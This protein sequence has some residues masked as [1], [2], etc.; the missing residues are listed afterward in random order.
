M[1]GVDLDEESPFDVL[2]AIP[3]TQYLQKLS[4]GLYRTRISLKNKNGSVLGANIMSGRLVHFDNSKVGFAEVQSCNLS[5]SNSPSSVP[6]PIPTK[7]NPPIPDDLGLNDEISTT[8]HR[9]P[10]SYP[11][12]N[13]SQ[14]E[15]PSRTRQPISPNFVVTT[16]P[17]RQKKNILTT[18]T[19]KPT[20]KI[21]KTDTAQ[22][23]TNDLSM[24]FL[25][26]YYYYSGFISFL[27]IIVVLLH[28]YNKVDMRKISTNS[29]SL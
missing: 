29:F 13:S 1:T 2:L 15:S 12:D 4:S 22:T 9:S 8:L 7:K 11:T 16:S 28:N 21:K 3:P 14:E 17:T 24:G 6:T 23:S 20:T 27:G 10:D 19:S 25:Q 18:S 5:T 26:L